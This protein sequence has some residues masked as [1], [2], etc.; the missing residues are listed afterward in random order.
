MKFAD[1]L[2]KI[3]LPII[4]NEN[5]RMQISSVTILIQTGKQ[6][7]FQQNENGKESVNHRAI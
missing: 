2:D 5:K 1:K 6:N 3:I 7:I 4:L